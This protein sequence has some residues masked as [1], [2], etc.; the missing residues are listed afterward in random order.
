MVYLS[1]MCV[2]HIVLYCSYFAGITILNKQ[3]KLNEIWKNHLYTHDQQEGVPFRE[4]SME[5][6]ENKTKHEKQ[7]TTYEKKR[8][9]IN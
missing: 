4:I 7:S 6:K 8:L 2:L 5:G 1:K 3:F 9:K